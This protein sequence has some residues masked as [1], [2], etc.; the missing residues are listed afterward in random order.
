MTYN[1]HECISNHSDT[2]L[3]DHHGIQIRQSECY[4]DWKPLVDDLCHV[5][6]S[7]VYVTCEGSTEDRHTVPDETLHPTEDDTVGKD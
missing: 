6:T 1:H 5:Y 2:Y 7:R 4:D 3:P